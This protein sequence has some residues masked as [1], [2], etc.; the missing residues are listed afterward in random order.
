[1]ARQRLYEN[2]AA[3]VKAFRERKGVVTLTVDLPADVALG[4][5]EYLRF[6]DL[7]KSDVIVKL[8]RS[9]L[10]RKR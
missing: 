9:Q 2:D 7:K 6:K 10:L 3:R 1:M 8:I 5:E 4:F